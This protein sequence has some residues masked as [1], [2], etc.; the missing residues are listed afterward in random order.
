[1]QCV[2]IVIM[3]LA[4]GRYL[5]ASPIMDSTVTWKKDKGDQ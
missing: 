1:M 5:S 3:N 2:L 4:E